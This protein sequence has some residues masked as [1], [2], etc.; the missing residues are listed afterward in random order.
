MQILIKYAVVKIQNAR[1]SLIQEFV[2]QPG[3]LFHAPNIIIMHSTVK[4]CMSA[5][6]LR[7][8]VF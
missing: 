6:Y 2:K 1:V 5:Y 8:P 7:L 3:G 4:I